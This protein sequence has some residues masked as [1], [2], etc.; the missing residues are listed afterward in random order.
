M[1]SNPHDALFKSVFGQP[2]HARGALR[3]IVPPALAEA[4]DWSTLT[5][6]PG[7]FVDATLTHQ[8]TDL[9]YAATWRNGGEALVYLLFEHQSTPPTEGLMAERLLGYQ[10]RIWDRWRADHPKA[11]TLPMI[12]PIVMYHGAS[13][14]SEPRSFDALLDVPAG[15]RPTVEPYLVRFTY[16]LHDLSKISDDELRDGAMRTALAKLVAMCFKHARTR[17]DFLQIL[18]RWIDVVREVVRAP[19]GLEALA[20]VMRYILEVNEHVGPEALQALLERDLG[21]EAKDAIMTAGQQIFEQGREKGRQQGIQELLLLLLRQRF[22]D[23]VDAHVEQ[24]IATA[25]IEQIEAWSVRVL[26]AATLAELFAD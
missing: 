13:S 14:W 23:S 12:L 11:K 16:L 15:L 21:P 2:E 19:H 20:Q 10:I 5:L 22:G 26:S 17:A 1:I 24:R 25:S 7:S 18:G 9:L 6:Q 3:A 8:H 4:L